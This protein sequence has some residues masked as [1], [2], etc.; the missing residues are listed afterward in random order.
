MRESRNVHHFAEH[1]SMKV[2]KSLNRRDGYPDR[3]MTPG[4]LCPNCKIA[5]VM[6]E[7]QGIEIDYCRSAEAY[8]SPRG[9]LDKIIERGATPTVA[10][11]GQ[12]HY[13]AQQGT[14]HSYR[15]SPSTNYLVSRSGAAQSD[16]RL[17]RQ[18]VE[19]KR[20][21]V[22]IAFTLGCERRPLSYF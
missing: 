5:L 7:R 12:A 9:E 3:I 2:S 4:M 14:S 20:L 19:R 16:R 1:R 8:G 13:T 15:D 21:A 17:G 22:H 10:Q 6:S 18:P 11:P